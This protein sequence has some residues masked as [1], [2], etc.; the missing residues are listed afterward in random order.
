MAKHR[1][2]GW[3]GII[4]VTLIVGLLAGAAGS[5]LVSRWAP[6]GLVVSGAPGVV[7]VENDKNAI[8]QAAAKA[9]PAVV[10]I[11]VTQ[12]VQPTGPFGLPMGPQQN[13]P[14]LGSGFFFDYQGKKY[15]LTNTHVLTGGTSQLA[16][17]VTISTV[18]GKEYPAKIVGA[19]QQDLAVLAP[20]GVPADQPTLPLGDSEK[21][22]VG[23]W[24]IAIGSPFGID[25][26]V[27]VGVISRKG[28]TPLGDQG[29]NRYVIQ[30]DA[31]INKGNSGGPL[32]DL[33]G[34]VIGVNE[35]ILSPTET[36][37]GIGFAIPVN[38]AKDLLYFLVNRGP[39]VGIGTQPNSPG[40]S[41]YFKLDTK[42]GVV[43]M[44]VAVGSPAARAG[45]RELDVILQIDG[46]PVKIPDDVQKAILAHKIGEKISF[47]IQRGRDKQTLTIAGGT[48]PAG[49]L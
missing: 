40:L 10:T 41:K 20:S 15:V 3:G 43:V 17:H 39:W 27:T 48:I 9:S 34:N 38:Q 31:A 25:N 16:D 30:T 13:I 19:S 21:A 35:M 1:G 32:I 44:Q 45:L 14:S 11:H 5:L 29:G 24:V 47:S 42:E 28:P 23:S 12:R 26:T 8:V 22:P 46:A 33:G 49:A 6:R 4:V 37:L 18:E 7:T 2:P 36:S